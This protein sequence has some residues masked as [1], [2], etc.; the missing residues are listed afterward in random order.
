MAYDVKHLFTWFFAICISSRMCLSSDIWS[1]F[2][3]DCFL[4]EYSCLENS[5]DGGA[6]WA[7]VHGVTKIQ[8]RLSNFT[9]SWHDELLVCVGY[10]YFIR[11][12]FCKDFLPACGLSFNFLKSIFHRAEVFNFTEI[13]LA[14]F[15]FRD[16]AFSVVSE[17]SSPN[18]GTIFHFLKMVISRPQIRGGLGNSIFK[19]HPCPC[20]FHAWP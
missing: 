13:Q 10:W 19:V 20:N 9:T 7:T 11:Y 12:V 18:Q 8:T 3:L 14:N 6:W 17:Q 2:E 5:M 15:T 1:T 4:F 16:Q